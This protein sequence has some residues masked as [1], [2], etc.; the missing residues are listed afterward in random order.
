M[1]PVLDTRLKG[2]EEKLDKNQQLLIK[3]RRVQ[4]HAQLFKIFYWAIIIL[5][6]CGA[7]YYIQPY[8]DQLISVYTGGDG[9]VEQAQNKLKTSIPNLNNVDELIKQLKGN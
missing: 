2:I 8:V 4:R 5:L 7:L 9:S 1:D 6:A 3:I